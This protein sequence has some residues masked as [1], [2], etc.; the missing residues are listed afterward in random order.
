[1]ATIPIQELRMDISADGAPHGAPVNDSKLVGWALL[2][3]GD[4]GSRMKAREFTDKTA[5]A[6]AGAGSATIRGSNLENP[7]VTI[8][9]NWFNCTKPDG[10]AATLAAGTGAAIIEAPLWISPIATVGAIQI[11]IFGKKAP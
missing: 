2:A 7:D 9:G 8:V 11:N 5:H 10:T 1:M 6:I 4:V 3:A